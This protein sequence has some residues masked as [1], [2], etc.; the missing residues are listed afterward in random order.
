[1]V[2]PL[3]RPFFNNWATNFEN[4]EQYT[5]QSRDAN[6]LK[7]FRVSWFIRLLKDKNWVM[8]PFFLVFEAMSEATVEIF[9]IDENESHLILPFSLSDFSL[10]VHDKGF[11][12]LRC[13]WCTKVVCFHST[14]EA[15]L[16]VSGTRDIRRKNY[17][18]MG[19][20]RKKLLGYRI[21]RSSFRDTGYSQKI[22]KY[23]M[24]NEKRSWIT[25]Y[26]PFPY[27][28]WWVD[29]NEKYISVKQTVFD[30]QPQ[31][32]YFDFRDVCNRHLWDTGYL[33]KK[34]Q[35]YGILRPPPALRG[36]HFSGELYYTLF[37]DRVY[38]I[39]SVFGKYTFAWIERMRWIFSYTWDKNLYNRKDYKYTW[40]KPTR[41][42]CHNFETNDQSLV[43]GSQNIKAA[44]KT[45]QTT[46]TP[47]NLHHA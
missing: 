29:I 42:S 37:L 34:L 10:L 13:S 5:W 15:P 22:V 17:R 16:G 12:L 27:F 46:V 25:K 41:I 3:D 31:G 36:P 1:M 21:L 14:L 47:C 40:S 30:F 8:L 18:D 2:S 38:A 7:S 39:V 45:N 26:M 20:L 9:P 32:R 28:C 43:Q 23:Q 44:Y 11:W 4:R 6:K 33:V 19:Y 24:F 35:G